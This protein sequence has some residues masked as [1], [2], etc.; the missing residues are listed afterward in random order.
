L[1]YKWVGRAPGALRTP[2]D[3]AGSGAPSARSAAAQRARRDDPA[4]EP[5][6]IGDLAR[7]FGLTAR[8][9][10]HYEDEGLLS[11]LRRGQ[12]RLY[13]RKDRARL[14]LICRGKRLGFSLSEIRD[15]LR[16]YAVDANQVEQMRF[17]LAL[18]RQ[19]IIDLEAQRRDIE[20]TLDELHAIEA[21]IVDHLGRHGR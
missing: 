16:L 20:Q 2:G 3:L 19:R 5:L 15:F 7:E 13:S 14:A 8:T 12:A 10:R 4:S 21:Q 6:T 18:A 11:P 1:D 17:C 9:I